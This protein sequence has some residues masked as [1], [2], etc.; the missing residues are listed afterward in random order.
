[1]KNVL[2]LFVFAIL[3]A[4]SDDDALIGVDPLLIGTWRSVETRLLDS[5]GV[6]DEIDLNA[7]PINNLADSFIYR[8]NK[9]RTINF[10]VGASATYSTSG[11]SLFIHTTK[12][13]ARGFQY[14]VREYKDI[15]D[16]LLLV[17]KNNFSGL[18]ITKQVAFYKT[19]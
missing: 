9:D 10:S 16:T 18:V 13:F 12:D 2:V 15:P 1:M 19:N 3:C 6:N 11:D 7:F 8:F 5:E 17:D 14:A 4:C